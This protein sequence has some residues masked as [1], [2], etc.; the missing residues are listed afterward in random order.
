VKRTL[1]KQLDALTLGDL[2]CVEWSDASIGKSLGS[3]MNV[4]VPV[5][6]WGIYIGI[7]GKHQKHIIISQN[8]FQYSNGLFDLDYTAIP[9]TWAV[10]VKIIDKN[11]VGKEEAEQLFTSF[12]RGGRRTFRHKQQKVRNHD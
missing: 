10:N 1:K 7:L 8:H 11:H 3:G 6:S 12:L 5:K 2:I 4:D 9:L